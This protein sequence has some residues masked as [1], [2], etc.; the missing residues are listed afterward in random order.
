ML[1]TTGDRRKLIGARM[2]LAAEQ[3]GFKTQQEVAEATGFTQATISKYWGGRQT[4]RPYELE[5]YAA[6]VGKPF[7]WF[8]GEHGSEEYPQ[9][10]EITR[11]IITLMM[12]GS[13]LADAI[14]QVTGET[15]LLSRRDRGDLNAATA[16]IRQGIDQAAGKWANASPRQQRAAI[17]LLTGQEE[18]R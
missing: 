5:R 12:E 2:R 9:A 10:I 6:A 18:S 14:D 4:P 7:A 8:G 1:T 11:Q 16:R 17:D 13:Y 3:A 15:D